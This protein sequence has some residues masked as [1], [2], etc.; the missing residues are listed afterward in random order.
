ME[1]IWG[2]TEKKQAKNPKKR[3]R[4]PWDQVYVNIFHFMSCYDK[5]T[6]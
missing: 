3:K 1:V 6:V 4:S 5:A 2:Y